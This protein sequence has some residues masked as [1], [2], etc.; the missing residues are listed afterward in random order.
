MKFKNLI[1][2]AMGGMLLAFTASAQPKMPKEITPEVIAEHKAMK[3]DEDLQLTDKQYKKVYKLFL[4]IERSR[5][6][7]SSG[8]RPPMGGMPGGMMGGGPGGMPPGGMG[9]RRGGMP[10]G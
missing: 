1:L 9:G 8:M 5:N 2:A 6:S 3:M 7:G 4:N 10:G